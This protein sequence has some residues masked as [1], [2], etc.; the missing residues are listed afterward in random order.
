M[1]LNVNRRVPYGK[2]IVLTVSG[3]ETVVDSSKFFF[4]NK[5]SSPW[6]F[7]AEGFQAHPRNDVLW[8]ARMVPVGARR[9][10]GNRAD[11][12]R[13]RLFYLQIQGPRKRAYMFLFLDRATSFT[14]SLFH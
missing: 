2:S 8:H 5:T 9:G 14:F 10:R 6:K 7:G 11:Q 1:S 12:I 4:A 3:A 13:V